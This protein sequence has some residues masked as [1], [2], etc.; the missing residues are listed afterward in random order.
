LQNMQNV[1][2]GVVVNG[3]CW[4]QCA[5]GLNMHALSSGTVHL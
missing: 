3:S 5:T 1:Q 4:K 2:V